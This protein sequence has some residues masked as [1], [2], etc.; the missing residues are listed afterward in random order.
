ME[1]MRLIATIRQFDLVPNPITAIRRERP[2]LI[3]VQDRHLDHLLTRLLAPLVTDQVIRVASRL[4][5]EFDVQ[6]KRLFLLPYDLIA[7]PLRA[8]GTPLANLESE[9]Y[10]IIS[11]L[12]LV[13]TGI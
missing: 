9:R 2:Y 6:G 5:P 10:R 3:C 1:G 12:D 13:F 11:A 4:N 7:L 8:L